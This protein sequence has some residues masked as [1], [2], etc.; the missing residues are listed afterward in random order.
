MC[1]GATIIIVVIRQ[2]LH[3]VKLRFVCLFVYLILV[4]TFIILSSDCCCCCFL[5]LS[6]HYKEGKKAFVV[7][8]VSS[9]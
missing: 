2:Y 7:L 5:T 9:A 6:D 4:M 8:V 1:Y 3:I